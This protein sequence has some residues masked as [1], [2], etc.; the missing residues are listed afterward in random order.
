MVRVLARFFVNKKNKNALQ[1]CRKRLQKES[2]PFDAKSFQL[3]LQ[4]LQNTLWIMPNIVLITNMGGA[5]ANMGS[6][7]DPP[8]CVNAI[9]TC[10]CECVSFISF[11]IFFI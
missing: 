4:H 6:Q 8:L 1:I 10:V 5:M 9:M 11:L 3:P 2:R 7:E